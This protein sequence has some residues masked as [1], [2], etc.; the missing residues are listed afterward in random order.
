M[1]TRAITIGTRGSRLA[2]AQAREVVSALRT[3]WPGREFAVKAIRTAGDAHARPPAP[4][5]ASRGAFVKE[6]EEELLRGGCDIAVHSMKDLPTALPPGLAVAAVP[7]RADPFDLLVTLDGEEISGLPPGARIGTSSARRA[8]LLLNLRPDLEITPIRGNVETRL[9]RLREGAC[10]GVVLAAAGLARL[11]LGGFPVQ[12]LVPPA[13]LPAP[14]QG[15]LALETREDDAEAARLARAMDHALSHAAARAE[16]AFLAALGGG[17]ALPVGAY[18]EQGAAPG[19]LILRGCVL[20]PDGREAARGEA[21]GEIAR[22][23]ELGGRLA[24]RLARTGGG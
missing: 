18:A 22:P 20:S 11:G 17:C 10:E 2:L 8:A 13:F 15:C 3:A 23:E 6:I 5:A 4:G 24:G 1:K 16:R 14:G 12:R 7:K 21:A 19:T 9:R